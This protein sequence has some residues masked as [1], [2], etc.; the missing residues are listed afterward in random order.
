MRAKGLCPLPPVLAL[1]HELSLPL[2][3]LLLSGPTAPL[4]S[5]E[6]PQPKLTSIQHLLCAKCCVPRMSQCSS[7]CALH[8]P[9]GRSMEMWPF[10]SQPTLCPWRFSPHFV[11]EVALPWGSNPGLSGSRSLQQP[12]LRRAVTRVCRACLWLL[13]SA[14]F[15]NRHD[16]LG[17]ERAPCCDAGAYRD[18]GLGPEIALT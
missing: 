4:T 5:E 9:R 8:T 14:R 12:L 13:W 1:A 18:L 3:G 2:I 7:C 6:R 16:S 15:S 11:N 10:G 17:T